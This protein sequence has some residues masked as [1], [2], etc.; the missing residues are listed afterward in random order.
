VGAHGDRDCARDEAGLTIMNL[1]DLQRRLRALRAP[2]RVE[3]ELDEELAF[4][5]EREIRKHIEDGVTPDEARRRARATF[6]SVALVADQCRDARGISFVDDCAR[7]IVYAFRTFRRAPLAALTIVTTVALGLGL[8]TVVFAALNVLMFRVDDV[9]NPGELFA[10]ERPRQS[11]GDRVL[12]TR[13]DYEALRRETDVFMD[14]FAMLPDIDSRIDGRMMAGT[15]VTGNFFNALR[16]S[17]LFGRALTLAD[18]APGGGQPVIVLSYRGWS[19]LFANDPT[20]IGRRVIVN[21]SSF[22]ILG[23]M[24]EGFRG[25]GVGSPDYWAPLSLLGQ[26]RPI[27]A[28]HED[29][30]GRDI[31]GR[32]K[33]GLSRKSALLRLLVWNAGRLGPR[34]DERQ[35]VSLIL[36]P[37][38]GTIPQ[39]LEA[40][41]VFTP[42]FF[43]FGLILMIGCANVANLLLARAVSRQREIG[44]RLSLGASR[45]RITRQLL[46]E[47]LALALA[48]AAL[49]L[50]ISR[51][52]LVGTMYVVT[53][54]MAPE[55]AENIHVG[56]APATDW[57][58]VAFLVGSAIVATVLFGLAPALQAT[59]L[60]LVRTIRGD[61]TRTGHQGRIRNWMIGIQVTASA[62]LLICAGVFLR[63]ALASSTFNPGL[64][65][66]D[67]VMVEII[68]E[69]TRTAMIQAVMAEPAVVA[70]AASSPDA[71]SPPRTGLAEAQTSK[72]PVAYRFVS[73]EY[74]NVLGVDVVRGRGFSQAERTGDASVLVVSERLAR[75]LWPAGDA[76]GQSLRLGPDPNTAARS[77][78]EPFLP[79]RTFTVVGIARDVAGFRRAGFEEIGVYVPISAT[80][81]RT[82]LTVRVQGDPDQA[83]LALLKRLTAIDPNMGQVV[84]MRAI[85]RMESYLLSIAFGVTLALGALALALTLSG[86]FSVLSYLVEQRAK[87]I[88][89]R[90][91]LG[92][93]ARNIG[94]LVLSQSVHP[95]GFG[96]IAGVALAASLG[97]VLMALPA[98]AQIGDVVRVF[99][100]VAYAG[101]LLFIV[102]TCAL[103]ALIPAVR[104]ARIQ[105]IV[106]LRQE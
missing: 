67:T 85:A 36:E 12:L 46:T 87:E 20:V 101:S 16:V 71:F 58:V 34:A 73:P 31:V 9:P 75:E 103:A 81:A 89:V 3:R 4:H 51:V 21:G 43:A 72:S 37:R 53:R 106:T 105:P 14:A 65:T 86:I 45:W 19:R 95:V 98:A 64:R 26:F 24:P 35:P 5:I 66:E 29:A 102:T 15:L 56:A 59:R 55:L 1:R 27:H 13:G 57:R 84:T 69:S 38:Q 28:G 8:V 2:R 41:L 23:V 94:E 25:L 63:S 49:G 78:D 60:E 70:A 68:N 10:I 96:L 99:D 104:A 22:E 52:V 92:A 77:N 11:D 42:L 76:L 6:G 40:V 88:G 32:L 18:D 7:D 33:P 80:A 48:A 30:V 100:P 61:V 50:V 97:I 93:T 54:T 74:F 79:S 39:P 47:S 90:M 44:V 17:P 62:L 91:A 82:S 83:R